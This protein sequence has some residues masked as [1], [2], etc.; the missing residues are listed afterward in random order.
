MTSAD[1]GPVRGTRET[2]GR[3]PA[4]R[5][6]PSGQVFPIKPMAEDGGVEAAEEVEAKAVEEVGAIKKVEEVSLLNINVLDT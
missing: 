4:T 1:H 3:V 2:G 5:A 6:A